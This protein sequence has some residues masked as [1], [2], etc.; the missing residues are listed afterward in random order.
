VAALGVAAAVFI[1]SGLLLGY[2]FSVILSDKQPLGLS[3]DA[4]EA[5]PFLVF[6]LLPLLAAVLIGRAITRRAS[7][8]M[9]TAAVSWTIA[10]TSA[11]C[12]AVYWVV[13][14]YLS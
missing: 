5:L 2:S 3:S 9:T 6:A 14:P 7:S 4:A 11:L 8:A 12:F 13:S 10:L 1:Y